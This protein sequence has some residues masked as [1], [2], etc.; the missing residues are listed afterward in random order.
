VNQKVPIVDR[1]KG[2]VS[3]DIGGGSTDISIWQDDITKAKAEASVK[4]AGKDILT[5]NA[6]SL[7]DLDELPKLWNDMGIKNEVIE[8]VISS[9]SDTNIDMSILFDTMLAVASR[10]LASA[11]S[12]HSGEKPLC[13]IIKLVTFDLA[14]I[15]ALA[16]SML[17]DLVAN[18]LFDLHDE[19]KFVFC[20]N[21]S[22]TRNWL[23]AEDNKIMER[24]LRD[25]V[26]KDLD[27]VRIVFEQ[28]QNPK[29]EVAAGLV[30]VVNLRGDGATFDTAIYGDDVLSQK[31]IIDANYQR[32]PE[33]AEEVVY[34]FSC[35]YDILS[36]VDVNFGLD[37]YASFRDKD[38][39]L[40]KMRSAV[41]AL[42]PVGTG[43]SNI[44]YAHAFVKCAA[45]A[46]NM[47]I[48]DMK[49]Q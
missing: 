22:K 27:P 12:L 8:S 32:Y 14:M 6:T 49:N 33:I 20:G 47:L 44:T 16:G 19:I 18:D 7:C 13:D 45:V 17:R 15:V 5:N 36:G 40:G 4:F 28:S 1:Q 39:F 2:F 11:L 42:D 3:I 38:S 37:K 25:V 35:L 48:A 10:G 46:N 24:V 41:A 30:S 21:G 23:R 34:L 9:F 26:G 29:Q 43:Y 31:V